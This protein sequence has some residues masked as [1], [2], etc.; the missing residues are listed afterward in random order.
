V[1]GQLGDGAGQ[2]NPGRAA[3]DDNEGE[4]GALHLGIRGVL[5]TPTRTTPTRTTLD[6][7]DQQ[8]YVY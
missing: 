5:C 6:S 4:P 2:L 7:P 8:R 1:P 3:A